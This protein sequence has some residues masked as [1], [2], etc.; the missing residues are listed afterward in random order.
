MKPGAA[1]RSPR[2]ITRAAGSRMDGAVRTTEQSAR[3]CRHEPRGLPDTK[4]CP[5]HPQ[6]E[7]CAAPCHM[8]QDLL[9]DSK[10]SR[11]CGTISRS[12]QKSTAGILH[13]AIHNEGNQHCRQFW[14]VHHRDCRS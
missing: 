2:S 12:T 8:K 13:F 9:Y 10:T 1:T 6:L 5:R 4:G 7:R 3:W 11:T 14:E